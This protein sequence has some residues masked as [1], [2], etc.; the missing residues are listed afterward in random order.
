MD[1]ATGTNLFSLV[2]MASLVILYALGFK[3]G[4]AS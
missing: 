1:A 3:A 4:L 2:Y